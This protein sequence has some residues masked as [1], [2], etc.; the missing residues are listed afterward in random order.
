MAINTDGSAPDVSAM[1]DI[2]NSAKGLL[3]PR[4]SLSAI[5]DASTI[6]NPATSLLVYNTNASMTGAY[7]AGTGYYYNAGTSGSPLWRRLVGDGETRWDDLRVTLD[8]GSNSAA[9]DYLT[10]SSGPQIW[11]FRNNQGVESMSFTVQL[12]HSWK[13]GTTIYPHLHWSPKSSASGN[14]EWNL[15]YSWANYDASTPQVFPAITT[16]TVVAAGAFTANT[17]TITPLIAGNA[18][19]DG[20]GKKISSI[21]I[22]R[23]WRN[24]GNTADTYNADAGVL[25]VDFHIQIDSWGS[26]EEYIK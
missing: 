20:A 8:K 1:L 24:S 17:H 4:V 5:T 21:L 11:Y 15:E 16:S 13:E 14:V 10:G 9:L 7:A 26:R 25:F 6:S 22:C 19:I 2:V 12:P 23:L 18:G 3:I